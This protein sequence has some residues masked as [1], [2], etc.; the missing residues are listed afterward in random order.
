MSHIKT[1]ADEQLIVAALKLDE[2]VNHLPVEARSCVAFRRA[3]NDVRMERGKRFVVE[4]G[5]VGPFVVGTGPYYAA[6]ID[7]RTNSVIAR[8]D[9]PD[10]SQKIVK[11]LNAA[12][13]RGE[14][15]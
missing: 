7:D 1:E 6:V 12:H 13:E 11:A 5:V 10:L 9:T 15:P 3:A 4:C 8:T 2:E 14:L